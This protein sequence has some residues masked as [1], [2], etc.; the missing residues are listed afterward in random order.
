MIPHQNIGS[1]TKTQ[2]TTASILAYP[3]F[4]DS[5]HHHAL[6]RFTIILNKL[7]NSISAYLQGVKSLYSNI[8]SHF[9]IDNIYRALSLITY[10]ILLL[11]IL[12]IIRILVGWGAYI[13]FNKIKVYLSGRGDTPKKERP[14]PPTICVGGAGGG[15]PEDPNSNKSDKSDKSDDSDNSTESDESSDLEE[16]IDLGEQGAT[17]GEK[18][19][20]NSNLEGEDITPEGWGDTP[21][22]SPVPPV[23]IISKKRVKKAFNKIFHWAADQPNPEDIGYS[24]SKQETEQN[25]HKK[26]SHGGPQESHH[27]S[28]NPHSSNNPTN[29]QDFYSP[30]DNNSDSHLSN[31]ISNIK[32]NSTDSDLSNIISNIKPNTADSDL[33]D[34]IS[35]I[36]PNTT[37][38]DLSDIISKLDS[39]S[40]TPPKVDYTDSE[41]LDHSDPLPPVDEGDL[42]ACGGESYAPELEPEVLQ[43]IHKHDKVLP[44][45]THKKKKSKLPPEQLARQQEISRLAAEK[46]KRKKDKKAKSCRPGIWKIAD[47]YAKNSPDK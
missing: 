11:L 34:M 2:L 30:T 1:N 21:P 3:E 32:P 15:G 10:W 42:G 35:G 6:E 40:S 8:K 46:L 9:N 28:H 31:I 23:P 38:S 24:K 13:L 36:K 20:N 29:P 43:A 47:S 45:G 17:K 33:A 37:D 22:S 5:I 18:S 7:S 25:T 39:R 44:Q 16:D 14:Q 12:I 19:N 27:E 4:A 41:R 26:S